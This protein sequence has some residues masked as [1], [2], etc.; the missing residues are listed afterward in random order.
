LDPDEI[1]LRFDPGCI[2]EEDATNARIVPATEFGDARLVQS[3]RFTKL[4]SQPV[5]RNGAAGVSNGKSH[6]D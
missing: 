2:G 1:H 3:V 4:S 6:R 5:S